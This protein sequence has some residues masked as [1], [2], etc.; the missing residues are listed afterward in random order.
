MREMFLSRRPWVLSPFS[1]PAVSSGLNSLNLNRA[2]GATTNRL[3]SFIGSTS[4]AA[5]SS[6]HLADDFFDDIFDGKNANVLA[7]RVDDDADGT[8]ARAQDGENAVNAFRG[9]HEL[10]LLHELPGGFVVATGVVKKDFVD[11]H[12]ANNPVVLTDG[13]ASE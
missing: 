1:N 10:R 4:F 11:V 5:L 2:C 3:P 8:T 9:E 7:F 12:D 13:E 6:F